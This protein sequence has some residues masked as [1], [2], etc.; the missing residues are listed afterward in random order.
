MMFAASRR[1]LAAA[2]FGPVVLQAIIYQIGILLGWF[3]REPHDCKQLSKTSWLTGTYCDYG[4]FGPY[5]GLEIFL[6]LFV[7]LALIIGVV[8]AISVE[9]VVRKGY[10]GGPQ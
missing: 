6:E 5:F 10:L 8:L 9:I 4:L 7:V 1:Q 2:F 3:Y